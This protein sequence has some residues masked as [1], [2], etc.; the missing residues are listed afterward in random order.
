[1]RTILLFL[2]GLV[3]PATAEPDFEA[4]ARQLADEDPEVRRAAAD[5]LLRLDESFAPRLKVEEDRTA[6]VE[7]RA[8]L[9]EIREEILERP[10]RELAVDWLYGWSLTDADQPPLAALDAAGPRSLGAL[11]WAKENPD[12]V[13]RAVERRVR[14]RN[15]GNES[16]VHRWFEPSFVAIL[17]AYALEGLSL[18]RSGDPGFWTDFAGQARGLEWREVRL[19]GLEVRG[20]AVKS[21]DVQEAGRALVA[22]W[23]DCVEKT[24][25]PNSTMHPPV[26]PAF[27][28]LVAELFA[29]DPLL[30]VESE[31]E[32]GLGPWLAACNGKFGREGD[33]W[34][35]AA[36]PDD[37][38]A[39]IDP[40]R[41]NV[42]RA[43]LVA[44]RR[45]PERVPE[46]AWRWLSVAP[47]PVLRLRAAAGRPLSGVETVDALVFAGA[48]AAEDELAVLWDLEQV[49]AEFADENAP[50]RARAAAAVL[51][52]RRGD[53]RQRAVLGDY[54][55]RKPRPPANRTE[56]PAFVAAR[57][58][59]R[60]ADADAVAIAV[61]WA[62]N[63]YIG[64]GR[65]EI[66]RAL[67]ESGHREG[68]EL[69]AETA[70][71]VSL[72]PEEQAWLRSR[73]EGAPAGDDWT[74]WGRTGFVTWSWDSAAG[75]WRP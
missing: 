68:L 38:A 50:R 25:G 29:G 49:T 12:W 18:A 21:A 48:D 3:L 65:Y 31:R 45:W 4:L 67:L 11:A 59:A 26:G 32:G 33:R 41:P 74:A 46:T 69:F 6:D 52:A 17:A 53:A 16:R 71:C 54:I 44:L 57:E 8:A 66:L 64:P 39:A 36:G 55:D 72:P 27:E 23:R 35:C 42:L 13:M 15:T 61:R 34:T 22:Y 28:A 20:Y 40:A 37:F 2:F 43:A 63:A 5:E 70:R 56:D 62:K 60:R 30:P 7:A 24:P 14:E 9:R 47:L 19:R 58:L 51:L 73:V 1:M 75:K 10:N